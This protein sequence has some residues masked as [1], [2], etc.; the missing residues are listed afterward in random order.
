LLCILTAKVQLTSQ[1]W[2]FAFYELS[3]FN[4]SFENF[5][6]KEI[7]ASPQDSGMETETLAKEN[8]ALKDELE[9]LKAFMQN[10][11]N[12][13]S[14]HIPATI[15]TKQIPN[16]TVKIPDIKRTSSPS[17]P[18]DDKVSSPKSSP[19]NSATYIANGQGHLA[20]LPNSDSFDN[21]DGL[22]EEETTVGLRLEPLFDSNDKCVE[23]VATVVT[24][25]AVP[26]DGSS[27]QKKKK[28][29]PKKKKAGSK[30]KKK[31]P[32]VVA[33]LEADV[34][35]EPV[36]ELDPENVGRSKA[37]KVAILNEARKAKVSVQL[38]ESG[39]TIEQLLSK[40]L[41]KGK[42]SNFYLVNLGAI[43]EKYL[44][45]GELLPRCEPFYAM[46][47]NPDINI[48]RTLRHLG[49]G[50]DCAS[51]AELQQALDI[52]VPPD[53]IIFANPCKAKDHI[54]MA[55]EKGIE[56][57]TFDNV[58]EIS[59]IVGLYPEAKL[60]L[61][62][63]ADDSHS[64]MPFGTK[65][66]ASFAEAEKL[67]DQCKAHNANFVGVSFHV[68][69]GC[70]S[71]IA[72]VDAIKLARKV[73]DL[74]ETRGFSLKLLDIGGGW[75]GTDDGPLT[76][77]E[78]AKDVLPVLNDLFPDDVRVIAEP[79]RFFCTSCYTLAVTVISR[80][81]R[82]VKVEAPKVEAHCENDEVEAPREG[83]AKEILYYLSDGVYGSFNNIVFDH[84]H[85]FPNVLKNLDQDSK[86][87]SCLFGPT[88]DSIDVI[89][90][91]IELPELEIGDWLYFTNMGAYTIAAASS[92]NGFKPPNAHYIVCLEKLQQQIPVTK[93]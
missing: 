47:A 76:M 55:K 53:K 75:P 48:T 64:L 21:L 84:A 25:I 71:S 65:F 23:I 42:Y 86:Q 44:Q 13:H 68:G 78:I 82:W 62:I 63:L 52:G 9:K 46:K 56:M 81:E 92:F 14:N 57:M 59:K 91:N 10:S 69:S 39:E 38:V 90:K 31:N 88:C 89:C 80:R 22:G 26:E 85:P 73:F 4:T 74:A 6:H 15:P 24:D 35:F 19:P 37:F 60:V 34:L 43:V 32:T 61:R 27:K 58:A 5:P 18:S 11:M 7:P 70:F 45:W 77:E 29:K 1:G 28:K 30:K 33:H 54:L 16:G 83:T 66:G 51:A 41:D 3:Y 93:V 12:G 36:A 2:T 40:E 49:T 87:R 67:I 20:E 50:M 79:G 72:W 8:A 17:I